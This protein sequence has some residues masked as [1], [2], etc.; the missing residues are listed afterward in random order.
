MTA[1]M[2]EF[3]KWLKP[4]R[5]AV[6]TA[7]PEFIES[8]DDEEEDEETIFYRPHHHHYEEDGTLLIRVSIWTSDTHSSGRMFI[9]PDSSEYSFWQWITERREYGHSLKE[10]EL[11]AARVEYARQSGNA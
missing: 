10:D 3:L 1:E 6:E 9:S 8:E 11:A 4:R 5:Q 7:P 2:F